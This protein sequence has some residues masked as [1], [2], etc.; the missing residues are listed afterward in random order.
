MIESQV[1]CLNSS[2]SLIGFAGQKHRATMAYRHQ[3]NGTAERMVH[4]LSRALEMYNTDT[5][6]KDWDEYAER[7]TFAIN[8]TQ[9][10]VRG[11][12]PFYLIHGWD[13]RSTWKVPSYGI[14]IHVDGI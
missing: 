9:Y 10:C 3:A 13:P 2:E 11:D 6:Q 12:T 4:T 8:T 14:E 7:L 1:S 5:N